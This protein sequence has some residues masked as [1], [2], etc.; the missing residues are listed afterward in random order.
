MGAAASVDDPDAS[1]IYR[2]TKDEYERRLAAGDPEEQIF[3]SL[4]DMV[5][6]RLASGTQA[7]LQ[8]S[9][10][11]TQPG[12]SETEVQPMN[13]SEAV[14]S[15]DS[16]RERM[17]TD[18][19]TRSSLLDAATLASVTTS[20]DFNDLIIEPNII[21]SPKAPL[22]DEVAN[23]GDERT[24]SGILLPV[25][26]EKGF[27]R[28][29]GTSRA[30]LDLV[31]NLTP[32]FTTDV[33]TD[34][35][36]LKMILKFAEVN[37]IPNGVDMLRFWVEI[38]ELQHLP[39]HSYTHRRLRKIY[40]KFLSPDA[41]SPVCV[42]AQMLQD[43]EK[44]LE[45]DNISAGIYSGAQQICFIALERSVYPRFR[46]SKLFKKMQD[47]CAPVVPN[48]APSMVGS[49]SGPTPHEISSTTGAMASD[50]SEEAEDYSLMGILAHP[51]KLRFLKTFCMEAL[52]LE[53]LLFYLEVED[54]KRL[55]NLSFVVNK[56]RRIYD[57][58]CTSSSRNYITGL[59]DNGVLREIQEVVDTKGALV[60]K[61]FYEAQIYVFNRISDDIW[62]GFCRSQ[63]YLAHSKEVKP[64]TKQLIRRG[65]RFEESEAVHQKLDAL[66]EFQLI[67]TA[68]HY[69]VVKLIPKSVPDSINAATRRKSIQKMEEEQA[70]TPQQLLS[71]LLG[72]PFAKK[73]FKSGG[74]QTAARHRVP[75]AF[76]KENLSQVH[77]AQRA[78]ASRYEHHHARRDLRAA[79][80]SECRHVQED[81]QPSSAWHV[82]GLASAL[83]QVKLLQGTATRQQ[84]DTR[85]CPPRDCGPGRESR[86]AGAL[87]LGCVLDVPGMHAGLPQIPGLPA[88]FG[89]SHAVGRDR[90]LPTTPELP[91]RASVGQE[92]LRQVP[93]S[94][95]PA[96]AHSTGAVA[97]Q[98]GRGAA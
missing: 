39:S 66:A 22:D 50:G 11:K 17:L 40:D 28:A 64:D 12:E 53:N 30:A 86:K 14:T 95:Q 2:E 32:V 13:E 74:L 4:R 75:P 55:P 68:M 49:S 85:G 93:E 48:G 34:P 69:P 87:P 78:A 24:S 52:A 29:V 46:D 8:P 41:P 43:I 38:D 35:A 3:S 82:A 31:Q 80:E 47:F 59:E 67:D 73:Y 71:L 62:P 21:L 25:S 90:A 76:R 16:L 15:G 63:E 5:A 37:K 91:D 65:N 61:L 89:E 45:G 20:S 57:R 94:E 19:P 18:L 54:C 92:N 10:E 1:L 6:L 81:R 70:L 26:G 60:P 79:R 98:A 84:G 96:V 33:L 44:A 7:S 72:D 51:A 36:T 97:A 58:Y 56:T 23:N 83:R 27:G 9:S 88:L 42:T 77:D